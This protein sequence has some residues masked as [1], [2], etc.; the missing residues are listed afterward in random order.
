MAR[1]VD[2]TRTVSHL[3][4]DKLVPAHR[5]GFLIGFDV[6]PDPI[7]PNAFPI[8]L[9]LRVTHVDP[10]P[11]LSTHSIRFR[12]F[13]SDSHVALDGLA[14]DALDPSRTQRVEGTAFPLTGT[15]T[16]RPDAV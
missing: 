3:P 9:F 11:D 6:D 8:S 5:Q 13:V 15:G 7:R 16:V 2:G 14:L 1:F 10:D 4:G 12:G